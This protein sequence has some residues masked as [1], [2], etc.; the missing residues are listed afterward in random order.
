MP[1]A[2]TVQIQ[3]ADYRAGRRE[4]R[5]DATSSGGAGATLTV[6]VTS[7]GQT[8]GALQYS[9]GVYSARFTWP[10][11]PVNITVRSSRGGSATAQV[12]LRP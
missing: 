2:D 8:I 1:T 6:F 12:R 11:N 7:T 9:N 5:V 4:L 3:R 10:S